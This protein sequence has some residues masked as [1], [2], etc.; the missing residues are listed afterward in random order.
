MTIKE[1]GKSVDYAVNLKS[2]DV[3]DYNSYKSKNP[4][5]VGKLTKNKDDKTIFQK[6]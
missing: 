2:G 6:L 4:I 3:Y 1:D 5:L